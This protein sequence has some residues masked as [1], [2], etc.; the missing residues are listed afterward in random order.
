[1]AGSLGNVARAIGSAVRDR[2]TE[3]A[4]QELLNEASQ[5]MSASNYGYKDYYLSAS[6]RKIAQDPRVQAY[7]ELVKKSDQQKQGAARGGAAR[8]VVQGLGAPQQLPETGRAPA[9]GLGPEQAGPAPLGGQ[10]PTDTD[11]R[12]SSPIPQTPGILSADTGQF[13]TLG[14]PPATQEQ[15]L[16]KFAEFQGAGQAPEATADDV[17]D[18]PALAGLPKSKDL[19][20]QQRFKENLEFRKQEAGRR[21]Q[22]WDDRANDIKNKDYRKRVLGHLKYIDGSINELDDNIKDAE[23]QLLKA[24]TLHAKAKVDASDINKMVDD[25]ASQSYLAELQASV[26]KKVKQLED[27]N[28][29]KAAFVQAGDTFIGPQGVTA[30][31][32]SIEEFIGKVIG[33]QLGGGPPAPALGGGQ[34]A[35]AANPDPMGLGL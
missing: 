24:R 4:V 11:P 21:Q 35:P 30:T 8:D 9:A 19:A 20:I 3:K 17:L 23:N 5:G 31:Q 22:R 18:Q 2:K 28:K 27:Y 12:T 26:D 32:Q 7:G 1:M 29:K 16:G 33:T 6:R 25:E 13:Q 15:A 34:P 14:E 10:A